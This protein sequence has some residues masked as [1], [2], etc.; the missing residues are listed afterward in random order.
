MFG[1]IGSTTSRWCIDTNGVIGW[2]ARRPK[3]FP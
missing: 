3:R 1:K 2:A